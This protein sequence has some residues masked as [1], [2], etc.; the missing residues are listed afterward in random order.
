VTVSIEDLVI[1][2]ERLRLVPITEVFTA[3][4][5]AHFGPP[6]TDYLKSAPIA[7]L[8]EARTY[9]DRVRKGREALT[10]VVTAILLHDN[11]EFLGCAG[12]HGLAT[13][14]P[15]L[16]IWLKAGAHGNGYGK[17]AV[18]T[19]AAWAFETFDVDYLRYGADRRNSPSI[20]IAESLGGRIG[21][22]Y[23]MV[24]DSGRP[25]QIVEYHLYRSAMPGAT[26]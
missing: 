5:I 22:E 18:I 3:A 4:V 7:S 1:T 16:G 23:E 26:E 17:E 9:F 19:I 14:T 11:D 12:V 25:L 15:S 8:E 13:R 21:R 20:H 2:S 10:D 6:V 24:S